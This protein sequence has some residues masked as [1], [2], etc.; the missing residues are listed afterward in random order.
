MATTHNYCHGH[1]SLFLNGNILIMADRRHQINEPINAGK[2]EVE[3]GNSCVSQAVA[4]LVV[5]FLYFSLAVPTI[6]TWLD[7]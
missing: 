7:R 6:S 5:C 1:S 2:L 4:Y 3:L